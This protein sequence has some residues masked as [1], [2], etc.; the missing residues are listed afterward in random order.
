MKMRQF[1]AV[2]VVGILAIASII[3]V[4]S[5]ASAQPMGLEST[6]PVSFGIG[7]GVSVPTSD[8]GEAFKNGWNGQGFVRLNLRSLP[9]SPRA[10]FTFQ[11]FDFDDVVIATPGLPG[12]ELIAG[13]GTGQLFAGI[14]DVQY[15]LLNS[16][17]IRPYIVAGVGAYN[18]KT[19]SDSVNVESSSTTD[20]GV[21]GGAG[22]ILRLGAISAYIEGRV[23]NVY[24]DAGAITADQIKVVPVTFGL[25]F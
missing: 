25:V 3:A 12:P 14:A 18:F 17:S 2:I 7:G 23:D 5:A 13:G 1:A 20:F 6:R 11:K 4:G 8:A 21:N 10:D 15:F 16:G 19:E 22:I 9:F 24:T